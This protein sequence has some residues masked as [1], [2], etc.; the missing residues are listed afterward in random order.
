MSADKGHRSTITLAAL[1]VIYLGMNA[2]L[3]A[4]EWAHYYDHY[5]LLSFVLVLLLVLLAR[6]TPERMV[7]LDHHM[8]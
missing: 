2:N 1:F 7:A 8:D 5:K 6:F 4:G 3:L